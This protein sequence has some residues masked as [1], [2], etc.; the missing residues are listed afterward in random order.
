MDNIRKI[1]LSRENF[2]VDFDNSSLKFEYKLRANKFVIDISNM[3][4]I[5]ATKIA[6]LAST[7]CFIKNFTKKLC[8]LVADDEIKRAI[9]ILRLKNVEG[10]IKQPMQ[11]KELE[12]AS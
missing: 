2:I 12:F 10:R 9:S 7:Y 11:N 1:R 8:W 6:I 4:L 3:N 5:Y